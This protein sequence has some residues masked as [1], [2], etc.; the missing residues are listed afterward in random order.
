MPNSKVI[1]YTTSND[2][3]LD[4]TGV[5]PTQGVTYTVKVWVRGEDATDYNTGDQLLTF[6]VLINDPCMTA[7]FD[8]STG[9]VPTSTEQYTIGDTAKVTTLD[10]TSIVYSTSVSICP[11]RVYTLMDVTDSSSPIAPDSS[12]FALS[13][14]TNTYTINTHSVD[15]ADAGTHT[16]ELTVKYDGAAYTILGTA[17]FDIELIDPCPSAVISLK[18]ASQFSDHTY[19][20]PDTSNH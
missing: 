3:G 8:L 6:T 16:F 18:A 13:E 17:Q 11:A 5:T 9:V 15:R 19:Q 1:V 2:F 14:T 20:I 4:S 7:T 12:V 10:L